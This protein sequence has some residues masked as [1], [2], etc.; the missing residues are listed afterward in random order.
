MVDAKGKDTSLPLAV[1]ALKKVHIAE[2]LLNWCMKHSQTLDNGERS[3][4]NNP[5]PLQHGIAFTTKEMEV[6]WADIESLIKPSWIQSPPAALG[7]PSCGKLKSNQW[8]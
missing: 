8:H 6:L 1:K 4:E 5:H 3:E 7:T 2:Q